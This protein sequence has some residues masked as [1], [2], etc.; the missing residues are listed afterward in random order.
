MKKSAPAR[1][2]SRSSSPKAPGGEHSDRR[3]R[4]RGPK[5]ADD[6]DPVHPG[7]P[8]IHQHDVGAPVGVDR[9]RGR[10]VGGGTRLEGVPRQQLGED[11]PDDVHVVDDEHLP[12]GR[13]N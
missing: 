10:S 3:R 7:H 1:R 5:A 9:E 6:L 4:P 11:I 8:Q 2:A 12:S 13:R